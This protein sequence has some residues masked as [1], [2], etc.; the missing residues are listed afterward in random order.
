MSGLTLTTEAQAERRATRSESARA[1]L[2]G[3]LVAALIGCAPILLPMLGAA[4]VA[5]PVTFGQVLLG[6]LPVAVLVAVPGY[7]IARAR[8]WP[9]AVGPLIVS[10]SGV[11]CWPAAL[12]VRELLPET[13]RLPEGLG[14]MAAVSIVLFGG[15]L[16][17]V[18][19]KSRKAAIVAIVLLLSIGIIGWILTIALQPTSPLR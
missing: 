16:S 12:L 7:V 15:P 9:N 14:I 19:E 13:A 18:F 3:H 6:T 1:A 10:A 17:L 4:L 8:R 2:A 5:I 11:L